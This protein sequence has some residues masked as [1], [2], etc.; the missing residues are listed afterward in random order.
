MLCSLCVLKQYFIAHAYTDFQRQ[1]DCP[2]AYCSQ[3]KEIETNRPFTGIVFQR[4]R[5]MK[6]NMPV[7]Q[8]VSIVTNGYDMDMDMIEIHRPI[9]I[10]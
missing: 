3:V 1:R 6:F 8:I 7:P 9:P 5:K 2:V 10:V 4:A